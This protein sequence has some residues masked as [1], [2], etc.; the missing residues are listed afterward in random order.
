MTASAVKQDVFQAIADPTRRHV[1]KLLSEKDM[2]ISEISSQFPVSRTAIVKH[3]QVLADARLVTA[4]KAG[5]EKI[6]SL[7]PEPLAEV[8]E[9]ISYYEQFW[10]NKLSVLKHLIEEE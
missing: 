6:Y 2:P 3:L 9:W 7:Q 8:Q 5:R 4:K 10:H 1:L